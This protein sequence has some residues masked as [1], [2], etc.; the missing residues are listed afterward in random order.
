RWLS[1]H[2]ILAHKLQRASWHLQARW[3]A[4]S[5]RPSDEEEQSPVLTDWPLIE[6]SYRRLGSLARER[7]LPVVLIVY[8]TLDLL[9]GRDPDRYSRGLEKLGKEL[10]WTVIDV[11][12]VF[13]ENPGQWFVPGDPVHPNAAGYRWAAARIDA[14]L[15]DG[16]MLR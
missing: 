14:A 13:Q 6:H 12:D 5:L 16:R 11:R 8:P 7:N 1:E 2:S 3:G 10:G 9:K 4:A 15:Q